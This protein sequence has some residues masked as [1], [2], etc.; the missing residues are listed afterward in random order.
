VPA[1]VINEDA[2]IS[3][4]YGDVDG[5]LAEGFAFTH[6]ELV[7][8]DPQTLVRVFETPGVRFLALEPICV[9]LESHPTGPERTAALQATIQAW[10]PTWKTLPD[11]GMTSIGLDGQGIRLDVFDIGALL[12]AGG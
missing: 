2:F 7:P 3:A 12:G 10:Q 8:G 1:I 5:I 4:A 9:A 6:E 11:L